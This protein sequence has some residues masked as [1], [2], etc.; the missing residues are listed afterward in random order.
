VL[1][2]PAARADTGFSVSMNGAQAGTPSPGTGSGT[3]ILNNAQ[4]QIVYSMTYSGLVAARTNQHI[5]GPAAPGVTAGVLVPL[6]ATGT[7][8]GTL[9]GTAAVTPTIVGYLLAGNTYVNIHSGTYPG[10]EIRGQVLLD[11]TPT[12]AT[13]WGR[14]K[15]LYRDRH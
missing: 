14:I 4:D 15:Q 13:T 12:H 10:G 9:S 2:V 11:P 1:A 5:H 7:T 8:S 3:I 6:S